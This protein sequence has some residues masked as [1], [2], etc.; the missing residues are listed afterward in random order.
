[1]PHQWLMLSSS[2]TEEYDHAGTS[3]CYRDASKTVALELLVRLYGARS[4]PKEIIERLHGEV[5]KIMRMPDIVEKLRQ[6]GLDVEATT[7]EQ[8]A[9]KI[10]SD[11]ERWTEIVKAVDLKPN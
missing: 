3:E 5:V 2:V 8:H 10:K 11:L 7:P 4:T 1:M 9:A 6:R